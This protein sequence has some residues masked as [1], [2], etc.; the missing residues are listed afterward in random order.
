MKTGRIEIVNK[1]GL[2]ARAASRLVKIT[3]SFVA[4][5]SLRRQGGRGEVGQGEEVGEGGEAAEAADAKSIMA[6]LMLEAACGTTLELACDGPDEAEAFAAVSAL[7]AD[8]FG[9]GE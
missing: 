3:K 8:R 2:H 6:V 9:E 5:I 1:L 4:R 7:V